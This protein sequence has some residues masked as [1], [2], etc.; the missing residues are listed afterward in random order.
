[1]NPIG[2]YFELELR[3]GEEYHKNAIRLNTGRNALELILKVKKFR[4]V[5][6][7]YYACDVILE[8]FNKLRIDYDFYSIDE[9]LEPIFNYDSIKKDE[10]FLYINYFG[11]KDSFILNLLVNC[12]NLIIDNSQAF[13]AFPNPGIP[14]F[15]SCRK[16][17]GVTDGAYLYL[18]GANTSTLKI[19]VSLERVSHLLKRIEYGAES[20]FN[21]FKSNENEL[22]GQPILSMSN[23]TQS[24]LNNINYAFIKKRRRENFL[25]L[26]NHLSKLNQ[27]EIAF[28]DECVPM[29]YPFLTDR[30]ELKQELIEGK[31]F[32]ATY[33]A[34]VLKWTEIKS[35]EHRFASA[36]AYLPV[37]QRYSKYEMN[38]MVKFIEKIMDEKMG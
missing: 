22:V 15:Y 38:L 21:D 28:A 16:F 32:V 23:L 31:I 8:P 27:L 26:H 3:K 18:D 7:P 4:K 25:F 14:T 30:V 2:G 33:W 17:F 29:T 35:I 20:G 13:F 34:N 36:I 9:N 6:I 1:M 37:D 10:G 24:I 19:D 5:F 12:K 11:L